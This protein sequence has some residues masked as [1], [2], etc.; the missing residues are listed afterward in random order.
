M[1]EPRHLIASRLDLL[2]TEAGLPP[3]PPT[4]GALFETYFALL[5]RWNERI[6]LTAI[7]NEDEV[8][9]RHFLESI[10]A[11][12]F[13]PPGI[14]TLLDFGSGAGFPGLPIA[15]CRREIAVV[16]AESQNKKAAFLREV[17][18]TLAL[19][20]EVFAGRAEDMARHFDCVTL[21]A[22]DRMDKAIGIASGLLSPGACLAVLTTLADS[23]KPGS[24]Q[25]GVFDCQRILPLPS[26]D[27]RVLVLCKRSS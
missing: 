11:A 3:V 7:R 14:R 23:E 21:R 20:V 16:L 10:A 27:Q 22:V 5:Q 25:S 9:R 26:A 6:N 24:L 2:L 18:R 15:I 19:P 13:L 12:H 8:L 4:V 1:T 17:V